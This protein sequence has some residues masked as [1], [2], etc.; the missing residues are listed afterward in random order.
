MIDSVLIECVL[1]FASRR[2]RWDSKAGTAE[3]DCSESERFFGNDVDSWMPV[4]SGSFNIDL[5]FEK[6]DAKSTSCEE[7]HTQLVEKSIL[8]L[9]QITRCTG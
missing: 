6:I 5:A 1:F 3:D 9:I 4:F 8:D 7:G 2:L